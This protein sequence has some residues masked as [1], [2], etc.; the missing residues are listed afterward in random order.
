MHVVMLGWFYEADDLHFVLRDVHR[1]LGA[2]GVRLTA[3]N[4]WSDDYAAADLIIAAHPIADRPALSQARLVGQRTM[5]RFV[6]M[7]VAERIGS[8]VAPFASPANDAE[9]TEAAV[10]WAEGAVLKYDW[11]ARRKGV[12]LWPMDE[13]RM[14]FPETFT[15]GV[16][17]FMAYLPDD[18]LTYKID[19]FGGTILGTWILPT[20][21]MKEP[22]WQW[23]QT[24]IFESFAAPADLLTEVR[25]LSATLLKLGVGHASF[26]F[27]K[28]QDGYALIEINSCSVGAEA[29]DIWPE[30]YGENLSKA[31]LRTLRH[32]D[33][34][35]RFGDIRHLA[36]ASGNEMDVQGNV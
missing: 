18:P 29:W 2:E 26:D 36:K 23:N 35:P 4:A 34:I 13:G 8:R 19:A 28:D 22:E 12:F 11:S 31:V 17:L 10:H 20:R 24:R 16:D 7:K 14:P 6:R 3:A 15:P 33:L 9:L 5:N 32:K 25:R 1:R 30:L 21:N 27:M